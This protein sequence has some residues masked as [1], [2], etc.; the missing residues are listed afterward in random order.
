[1]VNFVK[2]LLTGLIGSFFLFPFNIPFLSDVNTKMVLAV[3]GLFIFFYDLIRNPNKS[4]SKDF[5]ILS[6]IAISISIWALVSVIFN[7]TQD[8]AYTSYIMSLWVWLGGAFFVISCIRQTHGDVTVELVGNYL[9]GVCVFQCILAY[10][11]T[12]SPSLLNFVNSLMGESAAFM[13]QSENRLYGLGAALDP[14]GLRFAAILI[15]TCYLA[16][17][18]AQ[19]EELGKL[20]LY[21]TA[22]IIITV[23]GNMISRSSIVGII[24]GLLLILWMLVF[25]RDRKSFNPKPFLIVLFLA[26]AAIFICVFFYQTNLGFR[27]NLRF[28]F[29]GFFS[30]VEKG[31][32][33]VRSNE[34]L[35]NMVVWPKTLKT[36]IIGDGY[37]INPAGDPNFLG[38]VTGGFYMGTDI[39]YLRYIFYFGIPGLIMMSSIF[40]Y[41]TIICINRLRKYSILFFFLLLANFIGWF[42][43]TSDIFMVFA[44]FLCMAFLQEKSRETC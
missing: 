25:N 15:I 20:T 14:A 10:L 11:M 32:W 7:H 44:P 3:F 39:G 17:K 24:L 42:K 1:M 28:G 30:L 18:S 6:L 33:E 35:K 2:I 41:S 38:E 21:L 19:K 12:L 9:I 5:F 34:I 22:V 31:R 40:V 37:A 23:I 43:V 16:F 13:G 29:E 4:V 36:W 26:L 27:S 8:Y